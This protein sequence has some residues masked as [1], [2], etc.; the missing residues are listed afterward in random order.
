METANASRPNKRP[1]S[2]QPWDRSK[3][4]ALTP[5]QATMH[6]PVSVIV[7]TKKAQSTQP[8]VTVTST[9]NVARVNRTPRELTSFAARHQVAASAHQVALK[10]AVA[11]AYQVAVPGTSVTVT[12]T[13]LAP[14]RQTVSVMPT[15]MTT[16]A[17]CSATTS[18]QAGIATGAGVSAVSLPQLSI[19]VSSPSRILTTAAS[20]VAMATNIF[21]MG[22][23]TNS[24]LTPPIGRPLNIPGTH[25][26][27]PS[28]PPVTQM[29]L[30]FGSVPVPVGMNIPVPTTSSSSAS[31]PPLPVMVS[32]APAAFATT[33]I[34]MSS[35][36]IVHVIVVNNFSR[37]DSAAPSTH[38]S[39]VGDTKLCPIAPANKLPMPQD[40]AGES[41]AAQKFDGYSR[42]RTHVCHYPDC[43]K[44]Y[45]KSSHLKAHLRTHTGECLLSYPCHVYQLFIKYLS[46]PVFQSRCEQ[47][48]LA[49]VVA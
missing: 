8:H 3:V 11:P 42:R 1:A 15:Q 35:V 18:T 2:P 40:G 49:A 38:C 29:P 19:S 47:S 16:P 41:A 9:C 36:P 5:Q 24:S 22:L 33:L 21:P 48:D 7:S 45:F 39:K 14:V 34:P 10:A 30:K 27:V 4:I 46:Q 17:S 12:P 13:L 20:T 6:R 23:Y 43:E 25:F 31:V 28:G 32:V 26:I 44:T 37:P